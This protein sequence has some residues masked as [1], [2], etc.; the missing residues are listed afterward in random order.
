MNIKIL[1]NLT[2]NKNL[3]N[4]RIEDYIKHRLIKKQKREI[5][6]IKGHLEKAEHNLKFV[7][8]NIE[9]GHLD[10]CVSGCYYAVYHSALA[11]ILNKGYSSKNHDATLCILIKEY[12]KEI[13]KEDLN[14]INKFYLD[15]QDL[16]FYVHSK[17]KRQDSTYLSNYKFDKKDVEILRIKSIEFINKVGEILKNE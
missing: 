12:Y 16:L 3:L 8:D 4:Y 14:L 9:I 5:N 7:K 17:Q 2:T 1:N 6:E 13:T 15:Y 11:L 10:W